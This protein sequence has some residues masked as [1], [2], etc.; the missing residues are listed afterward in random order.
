MGY[1]LPYILINA[2]VLKNLINLLAYIVADIM[3]NLNDFLSS[4]FISNFCFRTDIR[5]SVFMLL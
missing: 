2:S 5:T 4:F 1:D 3:I